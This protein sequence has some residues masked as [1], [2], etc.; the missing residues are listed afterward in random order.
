[1]L[2]EKDDIVLYFSYTAP[3]LKGVEI[4]RV[5]EVETHH[6]KKYYKIEN[7]NYLFKQEQIILKLTSS[8]V[9]RYEM[10]KG[11]LNHRLRE[12]DLSN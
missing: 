6:T 3:M 9:Q 8:Q 5:I 11:G 7:S 1:M 10:I 2:I 4:G 12:G